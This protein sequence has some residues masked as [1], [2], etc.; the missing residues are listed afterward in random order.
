M[1]MRVANSGFTLFIVF[2]LNNNFSVGRTQLKTNIYAEK[3]QTSLLSESSSSISLVR[4]TFVNITGSVSPWVLANIDLPFISDQNKV[5]II[6]YGVT[7]YSDAENCS[8]GVA[9]G[10]EGKY[11][12]YSKSNQR[13]DCS[14]YKTNNAQ[15]TDEITHKHLLSESCVDGKMQVSRDYLPKKVTVLSKSSSNETVNLAMQYIYCSVETAAGITT[16]TTTKSSSSITE[17][18]RV[19]STQSTDS[20]LLITSMPIHWRRKIVSEISESRKLPST[21]ISSEMVPTSSNYYIIGLSLG[22]FIILCAIVIGFVRY[23]KYAGTQPKQNPKS[24]HDIVAE[25]NVGFVLNENTKDDLD[26]PYHK[27]YTIEGTAN[28]VIESP[29]ETTHQYEIPIQRQNG[30]EIPIRQRNDGYEVPMTNKYEVP[31]S[32][33]T[34]TSGHEYII[35]ET[36]SYYIVPA[37]KRS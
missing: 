32:R 4:V 7:P 27:Y 14:I 22:A 35:P 8:D 18:E 31:I 30:Y 36:D 9:I 21:S 15:C 1:N 16:S 34:I 6:L 12:C 17:T 37:A 13:K 2:V 5:V 28:D 3:R 19:E 33:T 25:S 29:Y 10:V 23:R 26:D 24:A 20:S 11:G